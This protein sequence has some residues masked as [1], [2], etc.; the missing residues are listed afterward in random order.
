MDRMAEASPGNP[1]A[2]QPLRWGVDE[3]MLLGGE[4]STAVGDRN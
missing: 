1:R 3:V 4:L 2:G